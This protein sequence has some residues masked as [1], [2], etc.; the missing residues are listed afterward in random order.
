MNRRVVVAVFTF[1]AG[2]VAASSAFA[3]SLAP[4][5]D[6]MAY[7][8]LPTTPWGGAPPFSD[9]LPAGLTTTG[10]SVKSA[11]LFDVASLGITSAEVGSATLDLF[12][13]PTEDTGFGVSASPSAPVTVN[14]SALNA[15]AWNQNTVTW[16]TMPAAGS[17]YASQAITT[18]TGA[19]SFDVT[20]LL[21]DWIDGVIPNNGLVLQGAA[22]VGSSPNWGF[23]V[24]QSANVGNPLLNVTVVPEPGTIALAIGAV[25]ALIWLGR[26]RMRYS[27]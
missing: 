12:V 5:D 4:T 2:L 20:Q 24:F 1:A 14:V 18:S 21:K 17:L 6:A 23:V 22:P 15:G 8:F 27:K 16:N 10:H 11:L 3:A 25:P 13:I 19:I 7:E 26:R 9:Y